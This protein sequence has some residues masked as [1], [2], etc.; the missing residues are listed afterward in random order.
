MLHRL[1][2]NG[3]VP[4]KAGGNYQSSGGHQAQTTANTFSS[5]LAGSGAKRALQARNQS[6][7]ASSSKKSKRYRNTSNSK[8]SSKDKSPSRLG[9]EITYV[10][11][12]PSQENLNI[13]IPKKQENV[14]ENDKS[15]RSSLE[16]PQATGR[17]QQLKRFATSNLGKILPAPETKP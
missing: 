2:H 1:N 16:L 6:A 15:L 7:I 5:L 12:A 10:G 9:Y 8:D 13:K 4:S 11:N 14:V 17:R 3:S